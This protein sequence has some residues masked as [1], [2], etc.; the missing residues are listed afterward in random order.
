VSVLNL[1]LLVAAADPD[2]GLAKKMRPIYIKDAAEYSLAVESALRQ[3]L[4][5]KREPVFEWS[6]PV[7]EGHGQG[8]I[9]LWLR[10]GRPSALGGIYSRPEPSLKGRR[11]IH[12]FLALDREKLLVS[13]SNGKSQWVPQEGMERKEL[14]NAEA[15]ADTPGTRLV[16]LRRLA[17]E[18]S[19][20]E[21][22]G[23]GK[24]WE[25]RLLP[26]PLYR[27]PAA[28]SGV[29]DGA[30]FSLVS[31]EGTDPEVILILEAREEDG[32]TRWEYACGRFA[33]RSVYVHRADKEVWSSVLNQE[34]NPYWHDPLYLYHTYHDKIVT[35]EGKVLTNFR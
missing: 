17:R 18:F 8:V 31:T 4:E 29:I 24:R 27:Y 7:R 13:R 33:G 15:P 22:D 9:F 10:E 16:Q 21:T 35:L 28:K 3:R 25:L 26:A 6:N 32:K 11:V 14:P 19:G 23:E 20:Y 30:L 1:I 5:L 34:S 2:D 12:E